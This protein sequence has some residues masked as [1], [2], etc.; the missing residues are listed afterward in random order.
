MTIVMQLIDKIDWMVWVTSTTGIAECVFAI[1]VMLFIKQAE[2]IVRKIFGFDN[3]GSLGSAL[4]SGALLMNSMKTAS[5]AIE[6]RNKANGNSKK[7]GSSRPQTSSNAARNNINNATQNT[8]NQPAK[9]K[10]TKVNPNSTIGGK[11]SGNVTPVKS[12]V[13]PG[14]TQPNNS[15]TGGQN[16]TTQNNQPGNRNLN[17]NRIGSSEEEKREKEKERIKKFIGRGVGFAFKATGAA[18]G[19]FASDDAITGGITGLGYGTAFGEGAKTLGGKAVG[20]GKNIANRATRRSRLNKE[21]NNLIDEYNKVKS[22][23][24]VDNAEAYKISESLLN[25]SDLSKVSVPILRDYGE[26]LHK[27]REEFEGSYEDPN[28]MVLDA[29]DKIQTGELKKTEESV[30]RYTRKK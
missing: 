16:T 8:S 1:I 25:V 23:M 6:K 27:Y 3:A 30:K 5:S 4:A 28:Q 7:S 14:N 9:V 2:P 29:I 17:T 11:G 20:A 10:V 22:R 24:H 18:V 15:T 12:H 13:A 26:V 21:T 19:A